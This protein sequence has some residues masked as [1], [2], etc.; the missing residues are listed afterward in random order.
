[1]LDLYNGE[2]VA[3]HMDERPDFLLVHRMLRKA[4]SKRCTKAPTLL[5]SDQ[6]WHYPMPAYRRELLAHG[7]TPSMSR[8]GNCLDNA[9][10]ESFSQC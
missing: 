6:G 2:I 4:L 8:R 7:V 3:Y 1:M 9:T 5:H 10:M